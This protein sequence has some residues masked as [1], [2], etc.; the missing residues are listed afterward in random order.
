MNGFVGGSR[1]ISKLSAAVT[2]RLDDFVGRR[3]TILVGDANGADKAV[4]RYFAGRDYR[5]VIVYYVGSCRNN[6]GSGP[7]RQI[8]PRGGK[9]KDF[10]YYAA[11]D[12]AMSRDARCGF[13]LW[14][15]HSRGTLQNLVRL[16]R[17]HKRA[18]LYVAPSREMRVL[19]READLKPFLG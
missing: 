11:K 18:L 8:E 13:M 6:L 1:A 19:T 7:T 2:E 10:F 15:A 12:A 4:Q 16:L 14:D 9:R 5:D 17:D 3:C